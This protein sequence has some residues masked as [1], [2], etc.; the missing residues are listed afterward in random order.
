[1][2]Q[3]DGTGAQA[4]RAASAVNIAELADPAKPLNAR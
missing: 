4:D 3:R 1:M 2:A